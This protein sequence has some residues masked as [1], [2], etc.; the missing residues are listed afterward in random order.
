MKNYN[1]WNGCIQ[2]P[3]KWMDDEI[4]IPTDKMPEKPSY[5]PKT[6]GYKNV[7]TRNNRTPKTKG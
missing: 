1:K 7:N 5:K 4:V 2:K 6:G 3:G